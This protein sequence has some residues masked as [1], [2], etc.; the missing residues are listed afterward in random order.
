MMLKLKHDVAVRKRNQ[1]MSD[2]PTFLLKLRVARDFEHAP[3][4]YFPH[5][6]DFRGRAYPVPP[7]LNH[8]GDDVSR[9]LLAFAEKRPLGK[10]GLFWLKVSLANLLGE[11]K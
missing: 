9:G 6:V 5:N 3:C 11:D 7:H 2:R 4:L 10:D 1:M 8:I